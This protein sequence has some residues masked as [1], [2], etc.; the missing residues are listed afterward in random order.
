MATPDF[1]LELRKHVGS[2]PLWLAG[3]LA[4]AVTQPGIGTDPDPIAPP[5]T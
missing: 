1:V 4:G 5:A 3:A 2:A